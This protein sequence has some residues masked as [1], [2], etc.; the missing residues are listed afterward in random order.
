[1]KKHWNL[2]PELMKVYIVATTLKNCLTGFTKADHM[3][4]IPYD[5]AIPVLGNA[6]IYALPKDT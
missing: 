1:M 3:H 4:S 2:C 5:P 6:Y